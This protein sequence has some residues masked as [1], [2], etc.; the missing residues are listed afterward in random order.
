MST[1]IK[2]TDRNRA[3]HP[4][5]FNLDDVRGSADD[6]LTK[7]RGQAAE[8]IAAAHQEAKLICA[9]AEADGRRAGES[10]IDQKVDARMQVVLA[11]LSPALQKVLGELQQLQGAWLAQ[12]E[13]HAIQLSI[14]IA[15]RVIRRELKSTPEIPLGLVRESLSLAICSQRVRILLHPQDHAALGSQVA[16]LATEIARLAKTEIIADAS[17]ELGGCRV[18]T[19]QG[20]IDQ[21]ISAQLARVEQELI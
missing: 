10:S 2:A 1:I 9:S 14:A 18:E 16:K 13:R 4:V 11:H 20:V 8:I 3:V 21:Q 12:W 17:I 6:Y 15:E 5:A 19:D 7:I